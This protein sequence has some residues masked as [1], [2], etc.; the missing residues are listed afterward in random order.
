MM[1]TSPE[2]QWLMDHGTIIYNS[3]S[4]H[5][6]STTHKCK[7]SL[8]VNNTE[9]LTLKEIRRQVKERLFTLSGGVSSEPV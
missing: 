1:K 8:N 7:I 2:R 5:W 9:E 3:G 6:A 4:V